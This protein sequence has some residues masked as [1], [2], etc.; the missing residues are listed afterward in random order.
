MIS[1]DVSLRNLADTAKVN[2][3][4]ERCR[5]QKLSAIVPRN[6]TEPSYLVGKCLAKL[7]DPNTQL[8]NFESR[9]DILQDCLDN[10]GLAMVQRRK[11]KRLLNLKNVSQSIWRFYG[12]EIYFGDKQ[13]KDTPTF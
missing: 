9:F 13:K 11:I 1:A 4:F 10:R 12:S 2:Y 7:A 5:L 8:E 6:L 3:S